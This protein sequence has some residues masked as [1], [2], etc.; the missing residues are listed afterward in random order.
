MK[1]N[2]L[3]YLMAEKGLKQITVAKALGIS[4]PVVS[5]V[6]NGNERSKTVEEYIAT[7][8]GMSVDDIWPLKK[9]ITEIA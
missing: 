8:F 4:R 2:Y 9:T 6:V 5:E 1:A 3:K 7:Q